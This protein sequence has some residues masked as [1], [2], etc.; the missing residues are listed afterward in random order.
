LDPFAGPIKDNTGKVRVAAGA[1]LPFSEVMSINWYV[2]GIDGS[3][4]K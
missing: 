2:E 3:I 4:P 1:V